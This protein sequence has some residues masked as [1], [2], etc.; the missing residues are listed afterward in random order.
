MHL[1]FKFRTDTYLTYSVCIALFMAA[2]TRPSYPSWI[3]EEFE[4]LFLWATKAY[5]RKILYVIAPLD[6]AEGEIS[7]AFLPLVLFV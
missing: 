2:S 7:D 5:R 6:A 4:I 1:A 3:G